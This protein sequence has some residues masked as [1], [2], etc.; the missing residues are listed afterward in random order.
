MFHF[1]LLADPD[2]LTD[3]LSLQVER[4]PQ[5]P[6]SAVTPVFLQLY[7]KLLNPSGLLVPIVKIIIIITVRRVTSLRFNSHAINH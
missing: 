4:S 7:M 5:T 2:I 1:I 3:V 6:S